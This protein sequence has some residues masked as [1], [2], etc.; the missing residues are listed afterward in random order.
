MLARLACFLERWNASLQEYTA[1]T[2]P[3]IN[4]CDDDVKIYCDAT[5]DSAS[6]LAEPVFPT[7]KPPFGTQCSCSM[8]YNGRSE[9]QPGLSSMRVRC[10]T[11]E[12]HTSTEAWKPGARDLP[13]AG[14]SSGV[15]VGVFSDKHFVMPRQY[16]Y[17][18]L[19]RRHVYKVA[20]V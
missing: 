1:D 11:N 8:I 9:N 13:F 19:R 17:T 4:Y 6:S 20:T 16:S 18:S 15:G 3:I 5:S 12:H 7:P 2:N 10:F 14:K